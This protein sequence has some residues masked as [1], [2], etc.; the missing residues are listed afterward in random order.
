MDKKTICIFGGSIGE[1]YNDL[2]NGWANYLKNF[3]IQNNSNIKIQNNSVNGESSKELLLHFEKEIKPATLIL[4]AI[5]INDSF[6]FNQNKQNYTDLNEFIKNLQ[7]I[8]SL[9]KKNNSKLAFIEITKVDESKTRP[10]DW[11]KEISYDNKN[12][13]KYNY[14]IKEF[15]EDNNIP[16]LE[17]NDKLNLNDLDDGLHPNKRGHQK[18]FEAIKDFIINE[19]LI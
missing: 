4:I 1:G 6:Y 3:F 17:L 7:K 12:I 14:K 10:C 2:P 19:K 16:F 8:L 9:S 5:G 11:R 15:C 18:I 13:L